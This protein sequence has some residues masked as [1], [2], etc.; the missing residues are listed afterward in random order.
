M[1]ERRLETVKSFSK[2]Y[3]SFSPSSLRWLIFN[4][5]SNGFSSVIRKVG[6]RVLIDEKLFF[7]WIDAQ[8]GGNNE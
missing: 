1:Q 6:K 5:K 8:Q 3:P 4:Q 7:N 2:K